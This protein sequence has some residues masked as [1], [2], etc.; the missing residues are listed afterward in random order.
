MERLLKDAE[1]LS[2]VHYDISNF[3]DIVQA[4][5]EVQTNL[6]ISGMSADEAAEAVQKGYLTQEDAYK[7][8][9]TTA[10]ESATTIQGSTMA[11]KAAWENLLVGFA[12]DDADLDKLISDF[13]GSAETALNNLLPRITQVFSGVSDA[14]VKLAPYIEEKLP[15]LIEALKPGIRT[16]MDLAGVFMAGILPEILKPLADGAMELID[17]IEHKLSEKLPQL[18]F[19]FENLE[20]VVTTVVT[21]FVA[22][23]T[24][25]A[26]TGVISGVTK[27]VKNSESAF[28]L[29]HSTLLANPIVLIVTLIAGLVAALVTLWHTNED[30]REAVKGIWE[31]ITNVFTHAW[32]I[33]TNT[34]NAAGEFFDHVRDA[35]MNAFSNIGA[36]FSEKFTAAYNAVTG[37]FNGAKQWASD[38][39]TDISNAFNGVKEWFSEKFSNAWDGITEAFGGVKDFFIGVWDDITG[40]FSGAFDWFRGVG[41]NIINGLKEGIGG[42]W[43][44]F[45]NFIGVKTDEVKEEV[46][47]PEGIDAHSPSRWARKVFRSI[48]EG[49]ILGFADGMPKLLSSAENAVRDIQDALSA[50][51]FSVSGGYSY[52]RPQLAAATAGVRSDNAP[53]LEQVIVEQPIQ[54]RLEDRVLGEIVY[55]YLRTQ[56]R[57]GRR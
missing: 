47:G 30:F 33:A 45:L 35:I 39:W 34:W 43:N 41:E 11:M 4:I 51:P 36:W 28:A 46:T 17:T 38:R 12:R 20:T 52:A 15:E 3:S 14:V 49:G 2:G 9:G 42:L 31:T 22:Y 56:E 23:K 24:S 54:L 57:T 53:Q 29:L 44:G 37:A 6:E 7:R 32:E 18:S 25:M 40:V 48:P 27:A 8:M 5:H 19:V 16:A 1:A 21:A 10:R 55:R 50:D 26:I 13:V